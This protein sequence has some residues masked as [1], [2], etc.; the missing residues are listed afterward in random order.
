MKKIFGLIAALILVMGCDDGEMSFNSFDFSAGTPSLCSQSNIYYKINGSE[1]LLIDL[2]GT[3]LTN[4][5]TQPGQPRMITIEGGNSITYRNYSDTPSSGSICSFPAPASPTVLEEWTGEGTISVI[6]T[7]IRNTSD[8]VTGYSHKITLVDLSFSKDGET[9]R[10]VNNEFGSITIPIGF[11]FNFGIETTDLDLRS[12]DENDLVYKRKAGEVLI[13][14]LDPSRY[15]SS[16]GTTGPIDVATLTDEGVLFLVY[17][18]S[19]GDGHICDVI[20][21]VSPTIRER[22][23]AISGTITIITEEV[24]GGTGALQYKIRFSNNMVFEKVSD[25]TGQTFILSDLVVPISGETDYY[26]GLY[27]N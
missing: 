26:F 13:L 5:A 15:P 8:I 19:I 2:S 17:N 6:T 16:V 24:P 7:V 18:G 11:T 21:P 27:Q 20:A 10:I 25:T 4:V 12:C 9:T 23:E 22:W 14:N 3:P 1:V